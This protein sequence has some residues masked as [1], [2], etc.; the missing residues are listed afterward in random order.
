MCEDSDSDSDYMEEGALTS[1]EI[2]GM[3]V[4]SHFY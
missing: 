2:E 1:L 3:M 4:G